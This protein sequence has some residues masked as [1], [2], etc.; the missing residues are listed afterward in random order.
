MREP[1]KPGKLNIPAMVIAAS[2]MSLAPASAQTL[3]NAGGATF[4]YPMYSKWCN[5]YHKLHPDIQINFQSLG[6]GAGVQ[7]ITEGTLDFG[8]SDAPMS[9]AEIANFKQKRGC[10][11]FHFPTILGADVPAYNLK[12]VKAE[13]NFTPEALAGIFLG[14]IKKWNDPELTKANPGVTLPASNILVVHRSDASGT[15]Y[16]W[17]DYLAKVSP[18]W[19]TKV[20]VG[21]AVNWPVGVGGK[22][23]E[24]V[25]G[26]I[27]Q[28]PGS[29]GYVELAYAVQNKMQYG[30]VRNAAGQFAKADPTAITAAATATAAGMPEDFRA[31]ITNAPGNGVYPVSSFTWLLIPEKIGDPAKKK[32]ITGFLEWMLAKGQDMAA[33]LDYGRLPA[34]VVAREKLA[35]AKIK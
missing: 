12:G 23:N 8:A 11:V 34:N 24:G 28:I 5:E 20:G 7:Q 2:I 15:T 3:L 4:P 17:V 18:E 21:K 6:S 19:K 33:V 22:G 32:V 13:L 29:V 26:Q 30:K 31:S 1:G 25:S 16:V 27:E 9:D 35:I 14:T 10:N